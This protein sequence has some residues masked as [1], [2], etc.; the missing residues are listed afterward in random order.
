MGAILFAEDM[1]NRREPVRLLVLGNG[2][3]LDL[4]YKTG[5][6]DF[7]GNDNAE[8]E[9]RFPFVEKGKAFHTLGKFILT[10]DN[11]RDWSGLEDV[12]A[13]F[14][15]MDPKGVYKRIFEGA[16]SGGGVVYSIGNLLNKLF[17]KWLGKKGERKYVRDD[18]DDYNRLVENLQEYMKSVEVGAPRADSV[19]ARLLKAVCGAGAGGPGGGAAQPAPA[20]IYSFNYT[21][22]VS[23]GK[24]L[25]L[26]VARPAYV[27]GDAADGDIV[28]GVGDHVEMRKNAQYLYKTSN[29]NY[30]S[31][32]LLNALDVCDEVYI[33]GLSLSQGDH[34]YFEDFFNKIASGAYAPSRKYVRIFTYDDASRANLLI[35]LRKM[36][37]GM[38]K[39]AAYSDIDIIRTK[40]NLDEPKFLDLLS[41]LQ[42]P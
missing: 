2:F 32:N 8:G 10:R 17:G 35:N 18:R 30:H 29:P 16:T 41:R 1:D 26:S 42:T 11:V 27:H 20:L 7:V 39:L 22:L 25:G 12:L 36:N 40:D 28:L 9:G 14:G 6:S 15:S 19:A 5:Y 3:D 24:A 21:D 33:F 34:P 38:I 37:R 23:I 4:G 31:T 13:E